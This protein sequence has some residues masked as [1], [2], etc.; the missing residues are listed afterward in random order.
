MAWLILS[1]AVALGAA[2]GETIWLADLDLAG[3]RQGYGRPQVDRSI[4]GTPLSVAG[5]T[6]ERGVGSHSV[7]S[8]WIALDG[9]TRRFEAAVGIDDNAQGPGTVI[10]S[11]YVDGARRFESG[12]LRAGDPAVDIDLDLRGAQSLYLEVSDAGDSDDFDH[13]DWLDARFIVT[14]AP[15]RTVTPATEPRVRLTPHPGP[16]P[17]LNSALVYGCR[18][19]R[20]F[21]YRLACQG[22]RPIR[23]SATDLPAGL[24]LDA[25]S[26]IIRGTA[27]ARGEYEVTVHA[28]NAHGTARRA[29]RIVAGDKLALTPPLGWNDWY[30]H[31]DRITD[32]MVRE[33]GD[34]L[35]STGLADVG[36]DHVCIDDCWANA[37]NPRDP[38]RRGPARDEAG[39]ILPNA[40]FPDMPGLTNY[41]HE[42][43][44]KAG[45]YTSPG[46]WTCAGYTASWQHE[47]QDVATFAEWGFDL[48]KYDWCSYGSVSADEPEP[49]RFIKPYRLIGELLAAAPRNIQLNLCQYGMGDV[50][51]WGAEIGG[52][53]WRTGGDLGHELGR[54]FEIALRNCELREFNGPGGWNDPDYVQIGQ[55]GDAFAMGEPGDAPLSPHEQYSFVSLWALMAAPIFYSG[56]L[57]SLDDFTLGILGNA[58]VIEI[59]QDPLGICAEAIELDAKRYVLVKPLANGDLAVGLMNR[60][61]QPARVRADWSALGIDGLWRAR[62]LWRWEDLG[63]F[64]DA[65]EMEVPQRF[66]QVLRLSRA[67]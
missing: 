14:G 52:Q 1:W 11:I 49:E 62:D 57:A 31:Y 5:R 64:V 22:E 41:L 48:L 32:P 33:A 25:D 13:L 20:P 55:I 8:W 40:H 43:G 51:T 60:G 6:A 42:R 61:W 65:L 28:R 21:L 58:E 67:R 2:E 23:F 38:A 37:A 66:V 56:D 7:L 44:L 19:G 54:I 36:Y 50:W 39:R 53:S 47:A 27:P 34:L 26:G 59:N 4:R 3:V 10:V 16:A 29:L 24:T 35:L 9:G 45:I 17:R 63:Q 12:V 18:P 30:A 46:P 15:P